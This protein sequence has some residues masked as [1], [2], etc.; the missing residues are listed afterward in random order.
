[1][2][3]E[4]SIKSKDLKGLITIIE[5][6]E[7]YTKECVELAA[8]ELADRNVEREEVIQCASEIAREKIRHDLKSFSPLND[9]IEMPKSF[10][11]Q[12]DEILEVLKS[13]F[14]EMQE[15]RQALDVDVL[16]YIVG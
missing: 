11:L 5:D 12:R 10:I 6:A 2:T 4:E 14:Y 8:H 15:R 3:L 7:N 16:K 1:M 9:E 13:E